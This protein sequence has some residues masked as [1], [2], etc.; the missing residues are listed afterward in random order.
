MERILALDIGYVRIGVAISDPLGIFAQG[1][2]V[3]KN[4]PGWHDEVAT[5]V[6]EKGVT[7]L[8]IGLPK[9]T[10]GKTGEAEEHMRQQAEIFKTLL[11]SVNVILY[12]ERFTTVIAE[13]TMLEA[14]TSRA[15]RKQKID[16]V[17]ATVL[18]QSYLDSKK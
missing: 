3:L 18:L 15:G 5:L 12:D 14:D 7:T 16:Q 9:R 13:Q 6:A 11:P 2:C 1:V 17:A 4:K 10:D 8:L